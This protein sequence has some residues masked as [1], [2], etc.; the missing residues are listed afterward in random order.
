MSGAAPG[1][2][3]VLGQCAHPGDF[4]PGLMHATIFWGFMIL[5]AGTI[6]FFGKGVTEALRCR[7]S[8]T[9]RAS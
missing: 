4:W 3:T 7:S 5:T 1:G 6:E 2:V 8:P 9:C